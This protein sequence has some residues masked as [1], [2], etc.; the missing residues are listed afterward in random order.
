M[1]PFRGWTGGVGSAGAHHDAGLPNITGWFG[2]VSGQDRNAGANCAG[3]FRASLKDLAGGYGTF[4]E[5]AEFDGYELDAS[6][7][8]AI[9]GASSTVM[10][11]SVNLPTMLYLGI[12]A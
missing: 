3:V 6:R 1:E 4:Y 9:Y 5:N 2:N 11:A 12:H 7:S 8:N 10:P